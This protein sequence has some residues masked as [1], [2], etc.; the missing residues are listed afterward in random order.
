MAADT[1]RVQLYLLLSWVLLDT[2][3]GFHLS[4][5]CLAQPCRPA[6]IS[7][8]LKR[9]AYALLK[10]TLDVFVLQSPCNIHPGLPAS[11][12]LFKFNPPWLFL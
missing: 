11:T 7:Y 12:L 10:S 5:P 1:W 4:W 3:G 2:G 8:A 6:L 9:A